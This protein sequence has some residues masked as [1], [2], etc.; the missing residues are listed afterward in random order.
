MVRMTSFD[1]ALWRVWPSLFP[2]WT[3][4]LQAPNAYSAIVQLMQ[5]HGLRSVGAAAA[6]AR[7]GSIRYR[8]FGLRGVPRG[9]I[10]MDRR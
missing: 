6:N 2:L 9:L 7:D 4:T 3:A 8:C 1:V 5:V 10:W